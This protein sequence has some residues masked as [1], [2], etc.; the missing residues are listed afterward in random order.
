MPELFSYAH[1]EF[2]AAL[3]WQAVSFMRVEWPWIEGGILKET[4]GADLDPVHFALVDDGLLISYAAVVS[5]HV[6]HAGETYAMRGLGNVFTYPSSRRRG[7]SRRSTHPAASAMSRSPIRMSIPFRAPRPGT[8]VLPMCSILTSIPA[9]ARPIA[10]SACAYCSGQVGSYAWT[11]TGGSPVQSPV[12]HPGR[13]LVFCVNSSPARPVLW[14]VRRRS[15]AR[16]TRP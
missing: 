13:T 11:V 14:A 2:P 3:N 16:V 9:S 8:D 15:H 4:Y 5:T 1:R 12:S 6:E 10:S 7:Y